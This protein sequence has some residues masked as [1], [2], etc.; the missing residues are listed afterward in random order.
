MAFCRSGTDRYGQRRIARDRVCAGSNSWYSQRTTSR[1]ASGEA[2]IADSQPR[3]ERRAEHRHSVF[4]T[5][6]AVAVS[7]FELTHSAF[8]DPLAD[9]D[10]LFGRE[11]ADA[12]ELVQLCASLV[13]SASSARAVEVTARRTERQPLKTPPP[14]RCPESRAHCSPVRPLAPRRSSAH[15]PPQPQSPF[16]Q[17]SSTHSST[18][19]ASHCSPGL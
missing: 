3:V 16:Q 17:V 8:F 5:H 15:R 7:A 11:P 6:Y 14:V 4:G 10:Q 1:A 9:Q 12:F 19:D 13:D 18:P 2:K